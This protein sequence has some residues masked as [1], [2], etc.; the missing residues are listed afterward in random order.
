MF[1]VCPHLGGGGYPARSRRG[2]PHPALDGGYPSQVQMGWYLGYPWPGWGR[3]PHPWWG[4][5]PYLD[6]AR[7]YPIPG[8]GYPEYPPVWTWP[9][10]LHP[11]WGYPRYPHHLDLT[12]GDPIPGGGEGYPRCPL[13]GLVQQKEYSLCGG[14]YAS[15]VHARGRS[16]WDST[17]HHCLPFSAIGCPYQAVV[18]MLITVAVKLQAYFKVFCPFGIGSAIL[19]TSRLSEILHSSIFPL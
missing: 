9:G 8:R 10:V 19:H 17:I 18:K 16:C 12:R 5:P 7:G 1:S 13:S 6:L 14:R 4:V 15:C 2:V 3:V 11:W